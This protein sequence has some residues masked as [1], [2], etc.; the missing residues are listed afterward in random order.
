MVFFV[1]SLVALSFVLCFVSTLV[2]PLP[3][4]ALP[5]PLKR[6]LSFLHLP[7]LHPRFP[8]SLLLVIFP[9]L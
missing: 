6:Y 9:S 7:S 3:P 5:C 2:L 8:V 4:P 1:S